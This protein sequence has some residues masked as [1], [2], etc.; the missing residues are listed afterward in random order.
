[1]PSNVTGEAT[2]GTAIDDTPPRWQLNR[3]GIVNIYQY[4]NEVLHFAGGRLLLRGVNGSGKSTAMNM[5]L[6][7]LLTARQV[8]IDAAGEQ[9]RILK[10]WMLDGRDDA[11]PVGYLWIEFARQGEFLVCGCGIRANRQSDTVTTWWFVTDKRPGVDLSLVDGAVP[12]STEALRAALD[13]DE[14]FV[15]DRRS[16][17]RHA[18]EQRLFNGASIDQHIKLINVVRHPRV[19][20]RIDVDLA[21][22]LVDALPQLS[23]EALTEAAQPLED[24]EEHR[25]SVAALEQT[26]AAVAGLLHV[27]RS[28][29]HGDLRQRVKAARDRLAAL[30]DSER[31]EKRKRQAAEAAQVEL[32]RLGDQVDELEAQIRQRRGEIAALEESGAYREG[33]QLE[34]LRELVAE[35]SDQR[36]RAEVRVA[37]LKSR[38]E[39]TSVELDQMQMRSRG[40]L[41]KL[42]EDL[43]ATNELGSLCRIAGRPPGP[44][45]VRESPLGDGDTALP[46]DLDAAGIDRQI[47]TANAAATRRREDVEEVA[48]AQRDLDSAEKSL[49]QA[50]LALQ[51]STMAVKTSADELAE[52]HR[53]LVV[54]RREWTAAARSWGIDVHRHMHAVA[55]EGPNVTAL[56]KS[57]T[58]ENTEI[59]FATLRAGLLADVHAL[60]DHW[61]Q[62][63][64][65]TKFRL[66]SEQ[67]LQEEAQAQVDRLAA[68]TEPDPPGL[69]WQADAD[70]CIADLV[71]FAPHLNDSQRGRLEGALQAS[72]LLAARLAGD[73][74]LELADGELIAV[75]ADRVQHPLSECLTVTVPD[76]LVGEL[77]EG[78]VARLLLSISMDASGDAANAVDMDGNF[79]V[80]AL[81]G[82]H[83][84]ARAEFIGVTARRAALARAR[85]E[86]GERLREAGNVVARTRGQLASN[87]EALAE[88]QVLRDQLPA[89]QAIADARADV[90]SATQTHARAQAEREG[91]TDTATAAERAQRVA[92]DGLQ[93]LATTLALPRDI[94]ELSAVRGNL[95]ELSS[96]L[97]RCRELLEALNRS[98]A[99]WRKVVGRWQLVGADREAARA[100]LTEVASRHAAEQARLRTILDSIG[101]EYAAVVARRDRCRQSLKVAETRLPTQRELREVAVNAHALTMAALKVAVDK[102]EQAGKACEAE[103]FSWQAVLAT[104]GYID[105]VRG[106]D[107]AADNEVIVARAPGAQGLSLLVDAIDGLLPSDDGAIEAAAANADGVRQSL[108]GRR[109]TIG[110]GWDAEARQPDTALPLVVEVAGPSGRASLTD[111]LLAVTQQHRQMAGLLNR[112]QT[113]ALRELLQGMVA[114]EM[115]TK[116]AG[117]ERLVALMNRRLDTV[118]TAHKVGVRLRWRRRQDLDSHTA[119]LMQ[120]LAKVPDL[121]SEDDER[122]LRQAL[123]QRLDLV[124]AEQPD[125]PYRTLIAETLDYKQWYEMAVMLNRDGKQAKLSR[126]TP[127]S[128]GEK[129]LVTYLPLFAAVAASTDA[130]AEQQHTLRDGET[131]GIA[132]FVLLDDAFAK[133]SED[134]HEQLFGLLVELDLD[135]IATS[136]RLWGMHG[137]VP[138]LAITEVVRDVTLGAILLEHYRWDGA[139][140]ERVA[141]A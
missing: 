13:G 26:Q 58:D 134:N 75:S 85:A 136:E 90:R 37:D 137:S 89:T 19:G 10:A 98:V 3:A 71:D 74:S 18:V 139:T 61:Q 107:E 60:V 91:A 62:T 96:L 41:K 34:P 119:R 65:A 11:Q 21:A 87:G 54:A 120:L 4:E 130:L 14:V 33:Q 53:S 51:R 72:G 94:D 103:L 55:L 40:D 43:L 99:Q 25:R 116:V 127:L 8:R 132:R 105:A 121:R 106:K 42:N 78:A 57:R 38:A 23:E 124:R 48:A 92:D 88:A 100:E 113:D 63:V 129:K 117:A 24:L 50:E 112:K 114:K 15:H 131:P 64:S 45:E 110:A 22:H 141:A 39:D 140:L 6:P 111:S 2:N 35:L 20:D 138:A 36:S 69:A 76:R 1:M 93:R 125:A 79:R 84:K 9:S 17:Y 59:A 30:R 29:C 83:A 123:S 126:R 133:V 28:Y 128:E 44:I 122:E 81:R 108:L 31:D 5:L 12:L 82:R 80:G 66:A 102:R 86:A 52:R 109:D 104:P 115:A 97:A 49:Q 67:R 77:D 118:T 73:G 56:A 101:A 7:F 32:H 16:D 46:G 95:T 70:H 27:Y 47:L 135:L 68:M